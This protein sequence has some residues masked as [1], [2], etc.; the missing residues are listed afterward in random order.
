MAVS[1]HFPPIHLPWGSYNI[2]WQFSHIHKSHE[3]IKQKPEECC[4]NF[5]C[6]SLCCNNIY[7][8]HWRSIIRTKPEI[9]TTDE[10]CMI[11]AL[12]QRSNLFSCSF[13]ELPFTVCL[14]SFSSNGAVLPLISSVLST[15][16]SNSLL[17]ED[18]SWNTGQESKPSNAVLKKH[19]ITGSEE[20][21]KE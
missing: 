1:C 6:H 11:L 13:R 20:L 19:I 14:Q 4:N 2:W 12:R 8:K 5:S 3:K 16:E 9:Q 10:N 21:H 17:W 15:T 18:R 7:G